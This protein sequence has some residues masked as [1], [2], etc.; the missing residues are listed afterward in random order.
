MARTSVV[1]ASLDGM[2]RSLRTFCLAVLH[3]VQAIV[4]TLPAVRRFRWGVSPPL[5]EPTLPLAA[6]LAPPLVAG[7]APAM[8]ELSEIFAEEEE[9]SACEFEGAKERYA[10]IPSAVMEGI[11]I[12]VCLLCRLSFVLVVWYGNC[13]AARRSGRVKGDVSE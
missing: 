4:D 1:Q 13:A 7:L 8:L 12:E 3:G 11:I 5:P 2:L 9:D 10:D 6:P